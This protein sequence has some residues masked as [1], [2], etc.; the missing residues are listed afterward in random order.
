MT[1]YQRFEE[2]TSKSIEELHED[3]G[4]G[5]LSEKYLHVFLKNYFE[6]DKSCHEVKVGRFTADICRDNHITEIQTRNL[7]ALR[8]KL[9]YY[10]LEGYDV[11]V[12]HPIPRIRKMLHIDPETG[13]V[14]KTYRYPRKGSFYSA[15][16]ELYKIKYFLD[17]DKLTVRLMLFDVEE[18]REI[19]A[20]SRR[21]KSERLERIPFAIGESVILDNSADYLVFIPEGLPK[22]FTSKDYA[23]CA[24]VSREIANAALNILSYLKT[25]ER[26][27]KDGRYYVYRLNKY[28]E[29]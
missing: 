26:V 12:V 24:K 9:E 6:P 3:N 14:I 27:A 22:E 18:Y 1:D 15:I 28:F 16:P 2:L 10:M 20:G 21:R 13:A 5:T 29:P 25:V 7:N 4:V 23:E 19:K 8:E 11:T 17:W